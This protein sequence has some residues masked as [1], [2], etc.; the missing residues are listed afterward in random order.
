MYIKYV[1]IRVHMYGEFR[2]IESREF[3]F[4]RDYLGTL[5]E[6]KVSIFGQT[7]LSSPS[8]LS[9]SHHS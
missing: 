8:R 6:W 4:G 3:K 1:L 5:P 7:S 2:V 9:L